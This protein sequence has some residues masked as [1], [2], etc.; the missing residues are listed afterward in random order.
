MHTHQHTQ[1]QSTQPENANV[2]AFQG[3]ERF[4]SFANRLLGFVVVHLSDL[5]K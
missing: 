2:V 3:T 5:E 4:L 1:P